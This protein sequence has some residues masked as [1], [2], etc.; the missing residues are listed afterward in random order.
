M[1]DILEQRYGLDDAT[2]EVLFGGGSAGAF[3]A[4]FNAAIAE[5]A[6]PQTATRGRLRVF[7]DAGFMHDWDD[8]AYRLGAATVQD[9]EVWRMARSFWGATFDPDCEAGIAE[10]AYCFMVWDGYVTA[11]LPVLLSQSSIDNSFM[12]VHGLAVGNPVVA[13]WQ[14]QVENALVPFDGWLHSGDVSYHTSGLSDAGMSRGPPGSTLRD[15]L[16][17]FWTG[18]TPE[19]VEF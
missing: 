19:R 5:A 4:H 12:G 11:R 13:T 6:L 1:L 14:Q 7:V 3:G 17:R 15:V 16:G 2:A 10:P 9:S 8:P 18:D